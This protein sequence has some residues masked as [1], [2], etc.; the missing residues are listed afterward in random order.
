MRSSRLRMRSSRVVRASDSQCRNRNCPGFD[1]IPSILRHSG[2][3]GAGDGAVLNKVLN[4]KISPSSQKN[5]K[6]SPYVGTNNY[7]SCSIFNMH[8]VISY[9]LQMTT[10]N[11]FLQLFILFVTRNAFGGRVGRVMAYCILWP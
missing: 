2:I 11:Y 6:Y 7:N 3:C 5:N 10:V 8:F 4:K 1:P 9:C